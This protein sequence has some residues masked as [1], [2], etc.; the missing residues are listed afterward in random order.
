MDVEID[1][2]T[3][4]HEALPASEESQDTNQL[5]SDEVQP[6]AQTSNAEAI[7]LQNNLKLRKRT[8]T[9]CLSKL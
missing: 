4:I 3:G 7:K 9:G 6:K 5:T 2:D 8:K 1:E